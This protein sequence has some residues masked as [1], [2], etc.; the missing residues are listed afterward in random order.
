MYITDRRTGRP[1]V[2]GVSRSTWRAQPSITSAAAL[3]IVLAGCGRDQQIPTALP[4]RPSAS[5]NA[6]APNQPHY[7]YFG[8]PVYLDV[9]PNRMVVTSSLS[10]SPALREALTAVGVRVDSAR[11]LMRS[12]GYW[13]VWLPS[14]TSL[15]SGADVRRRVRTAGRFEFATHVYKTRGANASDVLLLDHVIVQFKRSATLQQITDLITSLKLR[16]VRAPKPDSSYTTYWLRYPSDTTADPLELATLLDQHP[17]VQW[18][19]PDKISMGMRPTSLPSDPYYSAQYYLKNTNVLNGAPVDIN[20]EPAWDLTLGSSTLRVA[21]FDDGMDAGQPDE[22]ATRIDQG[23]DLLWDQLPPGATDNAV[24]PYCNDAHGTATTGIVAASQNGSGTAGIAP[25]VHLI[26]V[27]LF[28]N[29]YPC[30]GLPPNQIGASQGRVADGITWAY[31]TMHADVLSN[32]W[33]GGTYSAAIASAISNAL[34]YGRGGLGSVVVFSTG[35]AGSAFQMNCQA[36]LTGVIAVGAIDRY[37]YLAPYSQGGSQM[38]LVAPSSPGVVSSESTN[39]C[40]PSVLDVVTTDLFG[41]AGC[42]NGPNGDI[43]YTS[44]FGGTSAAAPQ[45]SGAAALLLSREPTLTAAAV[46]ARLVTKADPWGDPTHFGY[47]KLNV[48]RALSNLKLSI[49][50][51]LDVRTPGWYTY[52]ANAYGGTAAYT[53]HWYL[54][55]DGSYWSDTGE[56]GSSVEYYVG[57]GDHFYLQVVVTSASDYAI[58]QTE[59]TGAPQGGGR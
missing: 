23:Y 20:V 24:F 28:R 8:Q 39:Y 44:T 38:A 25:N 45:V 26:S 52:T 3:L 41:P 7:M 17:L 1:I 4:M 51:T 59:I 16:V 13:L 29:D 58:A 14:G 54:S 37:G 10:S 12:S 36:A 2:S 35:N 42:N 33:G 15:D 47:G 50:G 31:S 53:Y 6:V 27:R 11:Q 48:F 22:F 34:T 56:T 43:N 30:Q 57:Y 5:V 46:K 40:D 9:D 32:S 49:H 19:D 21:M 55:G 18:A